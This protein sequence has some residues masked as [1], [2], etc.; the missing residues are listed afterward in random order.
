M[1]SIYHAGIGEQHAKT[2]HTLTAEA[3]AAYLMDFSHN[4]STPFVA[5]LY[6]PKG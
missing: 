3:G 5:S 4:Y 2:H 6:T 1:F